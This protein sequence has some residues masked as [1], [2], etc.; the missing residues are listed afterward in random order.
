MTTIGGS[1]S[2][3][4]R[5]RQSLKEEQDRTPSGAKDTKIRAEKVKFYEREIGRYLKLCAGIYNLKAAIIL[6]QR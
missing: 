2:V 6:T 1:N 3:V 4:T 5:M